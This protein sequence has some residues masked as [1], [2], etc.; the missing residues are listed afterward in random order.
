MKKFDDTRKRFD[1]DREAE[2]QTDGQT[3]W[4][5]LALLAMRRDAVKCVAI[6]MF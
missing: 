2:E 3:E 1:T 6:V 5:Y 4:P